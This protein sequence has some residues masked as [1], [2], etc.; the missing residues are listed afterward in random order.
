MEVPRVITIAGS[1]S[2]GGAGIQADVKTISILGGYAMTVVTAVTAQDTNNVKAVFEIPPEFVARQFEAVMRDVGADAVKTGMLCSR[3]TIEVVVEG[4]RYYKVER[5]VVDPVL[6][7]T[8]GAPL[9]A[10]D[11]RNTLCQELFPLAFLVT[12]NIPEAEVLTDIVI[13]SPSDMK[14]AA[15]V[16]YEMGPRHVLITGGHLFEGAV[17]VLYDGRQFTEIPFIRLDTKD[18]HGSGCTL[19]AAV[20]TELAKGCS[21]M[22]ALVR[23]ESFVHQSIRHA[24]RLGKGHGP[25]NQMAACKDRS[26]YG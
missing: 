4:I 23:A 25:L 18:T 2:C 15:R 12:P 10:A 14:A 19:S 9:L 13:T 8:G 17:H 7:A 11:A 3:G 26:A 5:L 6:T 1:D 22:E 20:A 21:L 16:L 24:F